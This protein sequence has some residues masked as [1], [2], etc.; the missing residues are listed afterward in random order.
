MIT[1]HILMTF[2]MLGSLTE[3]ELRQKTVQGYETVMAARRAW[4]FRTIDQRSTPSAGSSSYSAVDAYD[5]SAGGSF[6]LT[7]HWE[8]NSITY[9]KVK[10]ANRYYGFDLARSGGRAW[11]LKSL[12]GREGDKPLRQLLDD[13]ELETLLAPDYSIFIHRWTTIVKEPTFKIVRSETGDDSIKITFKV[14]GAIHRGNRVNGGEA[15][16]DPKYWS[17]KKYVAE[18]TF[19]AGDKGTY[20]GETQYQGNINNIPVVRKHDYK[21]VDP[22][23]GQVVFSRTLQYENEK[24]GDLDEQLA[25]ASHYGLPEPAIEEGRF[26]VW[27]TLLLIG[28]ACLTSAAWVRRKVA[29]A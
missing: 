14:N 19:S 10:A 4:S 24:P 7:R 25:M 3:S 13:D 1:S 9:E 28:A 26:P 6:L 17:L 20:Q 16:I 29:V 8:L 18:L 12:E 15:V 23:S 2:V 5:G 11:E 21:T 22:Q 27:P